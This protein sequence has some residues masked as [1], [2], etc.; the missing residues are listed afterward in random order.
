LDG[1][2]SGDHCTLKTLLLMRHAKS[3]HPVGRSDHDRPLNE[4]GLIDAPRM[5]RWL[6]RQ[7]LTPDHVVSSTALR[8][9]AT[10]EATAQAAGFEG[11]IDATDRLYMAHPMEMLEILQEQSDQ[12]DR[13]LMVSHNP[14]TEALLHHL[15][16][17]LEPVATAAIAHIELQVD[18]WSRRGLVS[19]AKLKDFWYPKGLPED[20]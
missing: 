2:R 20:F 1:G 18:S 14:G 13:V 3:S 17:S 15:S 11:P 16:G 5:G 4:R 12:H 8:A 9:L 10:A 19:A 6:K 7:G